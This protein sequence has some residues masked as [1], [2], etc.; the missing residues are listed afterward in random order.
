[1]AI[2]WALATFFLRINKKKTHRWI[3]IT[4]V[5][6]YTLFTITYM[7]VGIFQCGV[8]KPNDFFVAVHCLGWKHVLEPLTYIAAILNAVTDWVFTGVTVSVI[9][10]TQIRRTEKASVC[11]IIALGALGSVVS[12][13]RIPFVQDLK[14]SEDFFSKS[15]LISMLSLAESAIGIIAISA[16]TLRPLFRLWLEKSGIRTSVAQLTRTYQSTQAKITVARN[17]RLSTELVY[18]ASP[19]KVDAFGITS[20]IE[21]VDSDKASVDGR[22]VHETV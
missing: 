6:I 8:P 12:V 17:T 14:P 11:L 5:S 7:F 3:I 10:E 9:L 4:S 20:I 18:M 2:K 13:A 21:A 16:A 19:E 22:S 15:P 1:M